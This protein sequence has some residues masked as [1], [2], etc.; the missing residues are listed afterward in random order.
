MFLTKPKI[1]EQF[2]NLLFGFSTKNNN[3]EKDPFNFNMSKSV[4]DSESKVD[5]NREFFFSNL[6]LKPNSVVIQKQVHSDLVNII[7]EYK[8]DLS[9]DALITS[10]TNLGLAISTAD[11]TNIYLYDFRTKIISAVHSGWAGTEKKILKKTISI[12]KDKFGTNPNDLFVY[13]GPSICQNNYQVGSE[14]LSKFNDKY[15][16]LIEGKYYLDLKLLNFDMLLEEGIPKE[17]IEVSDICSFGNEKFHSYRRDKENSG[18]AF[19][20]I[21]LKS[22]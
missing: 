16:S 2:P 21:A 14:F 8:S 19:G 4:G 9:G 20:V 18:R 13:F 12:M 5:E 3:Y 7:D 11:C 15:F 17:Q 10:Q 1:F 22:L 6:G